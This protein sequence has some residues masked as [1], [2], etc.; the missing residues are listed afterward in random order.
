VG[1]WWTF[2]RK[3]SCADE[4]GVF[5]DLFGSYPAGIRRLGEKIGSWEILDFSWKREIFLDPISWSSP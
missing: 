2:G 1:E 3:L 5:A 4:I